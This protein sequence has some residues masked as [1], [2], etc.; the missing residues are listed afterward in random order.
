[1]KPANPLFLGPPVGNFDRATQSEN[2]GKLRQLTLG[3]GDV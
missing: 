2:P 1:M 3:D